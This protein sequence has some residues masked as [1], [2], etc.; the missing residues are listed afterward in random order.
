MS[1]PQPLDVHQPSA[2]VLYG[3]PLRLIDPDNINV[4]VGAGGMAGLHV[5]IVGAPQLRL[6]LIHGYAFEGQC[7]GLDRPTI[8]VVAGDGAQAVGCDYNDFGDGVPDAQKTWRMWVV[9]K[10]D[11]TVQIDVTEGLFEQLVL[12]ANLPGR[13]SPNT[14]SSNMMLSHRGGRLSD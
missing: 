1:H 3:V 2:I 14:Y 13:R 8:M 7:Y 9:G 6:A 10:L 4:R 5:A 11:R 12:D